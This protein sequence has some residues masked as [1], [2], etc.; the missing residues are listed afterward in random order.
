MAQFLSRLYIFYQLRSLLRS[1]GSCDLF[2]H[3]ASTVTVEKMRGMRFFGLPAK[4]VRCQLRS[5]L[6][7]FCY[8][9]PHSCGNSCSTC[10]TAQG[11]RD[12]QNTL[13]TS[14]PRYARGRNLC[15]AIFVWNK[16]PGKN[17]INKCDLISVLDTLGACSP[18]P[19][20]N[21]P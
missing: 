2:G 14:K 21:S 5:L 10:I 17:E 6:R 16:L 4:C 12:T 3:P 13:A 15:S 11:P 7:L 20:E 18:V 8:D 9:K 19:V 1:C